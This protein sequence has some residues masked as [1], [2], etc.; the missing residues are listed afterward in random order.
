M[1]FFNSAP[2]LKFTRLHARIVQEDGAFT[3][4]VRCSII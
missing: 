3:V 1:N 2:N 4:R